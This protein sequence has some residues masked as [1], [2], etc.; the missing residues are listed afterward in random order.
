LS[1][2]INFLPENPVVSAKYTMIPASVFLG[3][4]ASILWVAKVTDSVYA[5]QM[6]MII[7]L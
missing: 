6:E 5:I 2:S 4:T 1:S 7:L 3:L